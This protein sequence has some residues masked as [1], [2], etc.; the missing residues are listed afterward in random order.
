MSDSSDENSSVD[1]FSDHDSDQLSCS[2]Y[3]FDEESDFEGADEMQKILPYQSEPEYTQEEILQLEAGG[4]VNGGDT[5]D[6]Q[7]NTDW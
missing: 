4:N 1:F 3:S 2:S 7:A 5:E 6:R